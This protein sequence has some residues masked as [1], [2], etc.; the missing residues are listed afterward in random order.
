[1]TYV[2]KIGN[3]RNDYNYFCTQISRCDSSP[4]FSMYVTHN[5]VESMVIILC[6]D[7][8]LCFKY[9][10]YVLWCNRDITYTFL[11]QQSWS[12]NKWSSCDVNSPNI[13][14]I[15]ICFKTKSNIEINKQKYLFNG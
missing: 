4:I 15:W 13:V 11:Q 10:V 14:S 3:C 1:M 12:V 8:L 5:F 6:V 2:L 9:N 7:R